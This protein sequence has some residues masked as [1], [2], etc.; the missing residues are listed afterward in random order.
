[1]N[2]KTLT[3]L[4]IVAGVVVVLVVGYLIYMYGIMPPSEM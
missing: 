4:G 3:I 1:M 2:K